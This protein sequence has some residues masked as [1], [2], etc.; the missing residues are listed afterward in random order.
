[1][2]S[3]R[4]KT[5]FFDRWCAVTKVTDFNALHELVLLEEFRNSVLER[6]VVC[7]NEQ[8]VPTLKEAAVV[9]DKFAPT[10]K[11]VSLNKCDTT[12]AQ[13]F[14]KRKEIPS[15]RPKQP[16]TVPKVP[17]VSSGKEDKRR[18]FDQNCPIP[19]Y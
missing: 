2:E 6:I 9:A 13:D 14:C 7:L 19:V 17:I 1:M 4:E 5:T 3:A 16:S 8:K 18:G 15:F 10:H 11:N 12:S